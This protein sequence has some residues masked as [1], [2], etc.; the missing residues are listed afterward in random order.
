MKIMK[1]VKLM[2]TSV[3]G[4]PRSSSWS[5]L[6]SW[7]SCLL[8]LS[9]SLSAQQTFRTG[10]QTVSA[11][12]T[13]VD[14]SGQILTD[15]TRDD[16][17]VFDNARSQP[18]TVFGNT[19]RPIHIVVMLDMS[20]SM[21]GH[22]TLLR[23]SA[24]Q[25][26]TRLLPDDR[27]RVGNFGD[28]IT[29]SPRFTNDVDDLVR[30]LWMDLKPGGG[31]PLWGAVNVAMTALAHVEGRRVVLVLSDGRDTGAVGHP[32]EPGVTLNDLIKR[33][34]ME[35]FIVY[36]IGLASRMDPAAQVLAGQVGGNPDP[37]LRE[38][39][40]MTGGGYFELTDADELGPTFAR[41]ADELHRQY[42]LGYRMPEHDG[43]VH[44]IDVR[45]KRP[46]VTVRAR[47][48]YVASK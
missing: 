33:G 47:K 30:A 8:A 3:P 2:K 32:G 13:V 22:L 25:M 11:Y 46:S 18:L 43:K 24:V 20:G 45:V 4:F 28:R 16:F 19:R 9:V 15:L 5:S 17:I 23:N 38:L 14:A 26:F 42:L 37:G 40:L 41:V 27:A 6:A 29:V 21:L 7:S 1:P 36:A 39:A 12:A 35:D 10:T 44:R 31:T 48:S 34:Q